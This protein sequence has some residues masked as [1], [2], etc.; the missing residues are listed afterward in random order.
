MLHKNIDVIRTR[1]LA[2]AGKRDDRGY[3]ASGLRAL[4]QAWR[5]ENG[6]G[7]RELHAK[8]SCQRVPDL[9]NHLGRQ[10]DKLWQPVGASPS[11]FLFCARD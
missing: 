4:E 2:G 8:K 3:Q 7:N 1:L 11:T 9:G 6:A 5:Y 10:R